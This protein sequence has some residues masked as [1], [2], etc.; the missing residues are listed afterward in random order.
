MSAFIGNTQ[1]T[2]L[3]YLPRDLI[4]LLGDYVSSGMR[5]EADYG[6]VT[7]MRIRVFIG[8]YASPWIYGTSSHWKA[9]LHGRVMGDRDFSLV[10]FRDY[11]YATCPDFSLTILDTDF[12]RKFEGL[13][14]R[15]KPTR[16]LVWAA[17]LF[18]LLIVGAI[19]RGVIVAL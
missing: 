11:A 9:F 4:L 2:Y 7:F 17:P 1:D 19:Y 12:Q 6:L 16:Y 3:S 13:I 18:W 5:V 8:A 15:P 14:L 10:L